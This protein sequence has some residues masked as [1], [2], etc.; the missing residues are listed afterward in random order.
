MLTGYL[1]LPKA[2]E[3]KTKIKEYTKK[4]TI[5]YITSI[6]IYIPINIYSGVLKTI[7]ITNILKM[8]FIDGT[9]YHLWYFPALILGLWITYILTKKLKTKYCLTIFTI[10]F[11]IGLL[12]D[13]YYG[14][15]EQIN[16]LKITYDYIFKI[17]NYTRNGIFYVP[18]FL[19]LGYKIKKIKKDKNNKKNITLTITFITLMIIEGITLHH[20][21]IQKHDSMY[22]FLIP[23]MYY[24]FQLL[25][26][27]N[28][29][30]KEN[31][32]K[33]STITYIMHPFFIVV[34]RLIGKILK[35]EK[36][37]INNSLIHYIL[38]VIITITFAITYE[39]IKQKILQKK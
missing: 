14:I 30:E 10:L 3:N 5:I 15:T 36:I 26:N 21:E 34:I 23:L 4:I 12:G 31:L 6:I 28:N 8:I 13:S 7:N 20:Y 25:I 32:R 16:I 22:I 29:G 24:L 11:I 17:F 33:I 39:K 37:I 18:I 19:Y 1:I 27:N 38:V 2:I 35:I 9:M